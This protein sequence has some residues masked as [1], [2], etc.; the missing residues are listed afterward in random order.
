MSVNRLTVA[1]NVSKLIYQQVYVKI[2]DTSPLSLDGRIIEMETMPRLSSAGKP[3]F[4]KH[5]G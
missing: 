1:M 4:R 3:V 2:S 5:G